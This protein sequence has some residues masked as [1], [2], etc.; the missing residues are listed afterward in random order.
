ML[1]DEPP[2]IALTPL[3]RR[4]PFGGLFLY[5]ILA[6]MKTTGIYAGSFDLLTVGHLWMIEQGAQLFDELVIGIGVNPAKKTMFT[7]VERVE[8]ICGA[9]NHIE[10]I[11]V[12]GVFEGYLFNFARQYEATHLLR[13]IRNGSDFEYE[14]TM[15]HLNGDFDPALQTVFLMPPREIAE[16]SSSTVKGLIGPEGWEE[17]VQ[18]YVPHNVF[19]VL[20]K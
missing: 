12:V 5:A 16:V 15:R 6:A 4:G 8:I 19:K 3:H 10:N 17:I 1:S 11:P 18:K 7:D 2:H 13:G 14:Q 20:T 9:T